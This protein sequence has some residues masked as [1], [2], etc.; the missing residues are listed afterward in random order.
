MERK[1]FLITFVIFLFMILTDIKSYVFG[2]DFKYKLD[3]NN[4]AT[5]TS[6]YGD[7]SE[8]IIPSNIDGYKVT[9]I[10]DHA[11]DENRNST[12]GKI[13]TNI[14]IEEG[15]TEIGDFAFV[16]CNNLEN[17]ILPESLK[18]IGWQCFEECNKL[19]K[20]NIPSKITTLRPYTFQNTAFKEFVIP[21]NINKLDSCVFRLCIKLKKVVV[22]NPSIQYYTK[23]QSGE[24]DDELP[25]EN[26]S[27]SLELYGYPNSTTEE[28]AKKHGFIFKDISTYSSSVE[29]VDSSIEEPIKEQEDISKNEINLS[30]I[31]LNKTSL[32]LNIGE[33]ETVLVSFSPENA[34]N[35]S[36]NWLSDNENVAIVEN[37]KITAI[38]EGNATITAITSDEKNKAMCKIIVKNEIEDTTDELDKEE[39]SK[40]D[41]ISKVDKV[42][43]CITLVVF[44]IFMVMVIKTYLEK[45][46]NK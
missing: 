39:F 44:I 42:I 24:I 29:H 32:I 46:K 12:N 3:S 18:E 30:S 35:K 7:N 5:I 45:Y 33:S 19:K 40:K 22:Y 43:N 8:I 15:I 36:V 21:E 26:C 10:G 9:K 17:V 23:N 38:S 11:F 37:G 6:Y 20:I 14:K 13:L 2:S 4:N 28:Y 41:K 16:D 31:K 27:K 25:F 34:T 1:I